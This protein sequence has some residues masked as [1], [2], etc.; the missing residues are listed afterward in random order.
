MQILGAERNIRN[1]LA[2]RVTIQ[3]RTG[4]PR[5][6]DLTKICGSVPSQP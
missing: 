5:D 6:Y 2:Q 3:L 1:Y 4:A